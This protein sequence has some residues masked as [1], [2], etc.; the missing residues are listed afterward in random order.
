MALALPYDHL[1]WI[2]CWL[3]IVCIINFGRPFASY[4][5]SLTFYAGVILLSVLIVKFCSRTDNRLAAFFRL[6]YPALLIAFFY[7]VSGNTIHLLYPDFL[8]TQLVAI[9][10]SIFGL[11]VTLWLDNHLNVV[12]TELLSLGYFSYYFMIIGLSLILFFHRRDAE[13]KRF[14]SATCV[15]FFV[16]YL[17]FFLYPIEGPRW[18]FAGEYLN[19]I[20]GV[21]FWPMVK[22]VIDNGAVHGGCMPSSHVAEALV[23]MFFALRNY[24][25]RAAFLIP[26][27]VLMAGGTIYGRF[28][29]VSD[30]VVGII[31]GVLATFG[32]LRFYPLREKELM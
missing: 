14:M 10:K 18:H 6:L 26:L 3:M 24:G 9:E 12:V 30:V 17:L 32:T 16:S 25:R 13:I 7:S 15:T 23:V 29:Y 2:Y 19:S 20:H 4:L 22:Y 27:V 8:D 1:I 5:P 11:N 28:H 31:I 21:I